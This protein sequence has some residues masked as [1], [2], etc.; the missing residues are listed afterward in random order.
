MK[1]SQDGGKKRLERTI[2]LAESELEKLEKERKK[3]KQMLVDICGVLSEMRELSVMYGEVVTVALSQE[4]RIKTLEE[5][6]DYADMVRSKVLPMRPKDSG[7]EVT[8]NENL[9][10]LQSLCTK[11][12]RL[13]DDI[14][15]ITTEVE[16]D[17]TYDDGRN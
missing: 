9:T 12:E 14:N 4:A 11:I 17:A 2:R 16:N 7:I 15:G 3:N 6:A 10:K 5:I 1:E 8:L 13:S